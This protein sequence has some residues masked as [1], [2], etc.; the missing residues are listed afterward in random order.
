M[1]I[2][3]AERFTLRAA[4]SLAIDPSN[5][6]LVRRRPLSDSI[7]RTQVKEPLNREEDL[8]AEFISIVKNR[9]MSVINNNRP[10]WMTGSPYNLVEVFGTCIQ[11]IDQHSGSLPQTTLPPVQDLEVFINLV[12][13]ESKPLTIDKQFELL[14][15]ITRN[16]ITGAA[17]LGMMATRL[18][19]RFSDQRAYPKITLNDKVF[20]PFSDDEEIEQ[21]IRTWNEKI[22][23]FETYDNSG[24]NDGPGDS[25]YFWTHFFAARVFSPDTLE[26]KFFQKCSE[27][28]TDIMVF[29]KNKIARRRG[30]VSSHHEASLLGRQIGIS[31]MEI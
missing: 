30:V 18:M 16:N 12:L 10:Y 5:S 31:L 4:I 25:Y 22:A 17:N 27:Y 13:Q 6:P 15:G 9:D 7:A 2:F 11:F 19:S 1:A 29:I 23:K 21:I 26:S 20:T 8:L 24:R 14:L 3:T 28:G